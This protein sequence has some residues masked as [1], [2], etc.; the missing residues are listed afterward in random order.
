MF[1]KCMA[2]LLVALMLIGA[3]SIPASAGTIMMADVV[4]IA[5]PVPGEKP[6]FTAEF[7]TP[8]DDEKITRVEWS[9]YDEG[10]EWEK[11]MTANDTFKEGYWYVVHVYLETIGNSTYSNTV[12]GR[13]NGDNCHIAGSKPTANN[14]KVILYQAYQG[15]NANKEPRTLIDKIDLTVVK[16]VVGKTPT[17]GKV[18]TAQYYS[19]NSNYPVSNQHNGVSWT[20]EKS[21]NNINISNAFKADATY[22]VCYH[23]QAKDGYYFD[24]D[25]TKATI[26]GTSASVVQY[27]VTEGNGKTTEVLVSL[28]GIVPGDGKKE[29]HTL[30]LSVVAP[31]EEQKPD[32][33]KIEGTGYYTDNGING[34]STRIYK[35]GVAWFKS[36]S[37]Y[38]SPGTTETFGGD[39]DYTV[40][41]SVYPKDGYKFGANVSA[42]INGKTATVETMDDGSLNVSVTLRSLSKAHVHVDSDWKYDTD[43]HWK[44]CTDCGGLTVDR[45]A[46]TYANDT[47]SVC[48]YKKGTEPP[49]VTPDVNTPDADTPDADTPNTDNPD[50][51]VPT[52][53]PSD[54]SPQS[55]NK[56]NGWLVWAIV[57]VAVAA[58]VGVAVF[59]ILNIKKK[60]DIPAS[61]AQTDTEDDVPK[62]EENH[63]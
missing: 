62:Q 22:C 49:A 52:V 48:G 16:P 35:N 58:A 18:D 61:A 44:M 50:A 10:W 17:F 45:Q 20:N 32:Y 53:G 29:I 8:T 56:G 59:L 12:E 26:N 27:L 51:S 31:K 24:L 19:Q 13:I 63:D 28:G 60:N 36:A 4:G 25:D 42:K 6:D 54:G 47:C 11:D 23:L 46:H 7:S 38:F 55:G 30:D 41:L 1:K 40:K 9:E 57:G 43:S 37:S 21:G 33:T 3:L 39:T 14:T 15:S 2:T 34:A 5:L